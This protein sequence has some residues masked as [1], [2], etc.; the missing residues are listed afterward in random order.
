MNTVTYTA[1]G[2]VRIKTAAQILGVSEWT[3]REMTNKG[4]LRCIRR[5]ELGPRLF[6]PADLESWAKKHRE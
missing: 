3:V 6:S 5:K 4:E 1:G 2:L